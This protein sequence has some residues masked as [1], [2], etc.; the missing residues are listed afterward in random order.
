METD[1]LCSG[2]RDI[3][4]SLIQSSGNSDQAPFNLVKNPLPHHINPSKALGSM[5][6]SLCRQLAKDNSQLGYSLISTIHQIFVCL[7]CGN[8]TSE[9][10][11]LPVF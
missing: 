9:E 1:P 4:Q 2:L 3:F 6:E 8:R 5:Y 11:S 10:M 7:S